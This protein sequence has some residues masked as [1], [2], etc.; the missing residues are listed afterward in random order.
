MCPTSLDRRT[1]VA[2]NVLANGIQIVASIALAP[3]YGDIA[4]TGMAGE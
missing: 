2:N 1:F 4:E 3:E